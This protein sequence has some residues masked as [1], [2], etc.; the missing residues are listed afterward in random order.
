MQRH[1][2][3][4]V[5][6][7]FFLTAWRAGVT[8]ALTQQATVDAAGT[9]QAVASRQP[10]AEADVNLYMSDG[11]PVSAAPHLAALGNRCQQ[12]IRRAL[13]DMGQPPSQLS[14]YPDQLQGVTVAPRASPGD[15]RLVYFVLASRPDAVTMVSRLVRA[16]YHPSHLF[17]VHVDLKANTSLH[18]AFI[19][20]AEQRP[21]V[22]VLRTRRL[23]QWG[24]F[25]MVSALLDA[26]ASIAHRL[27]FDFFIN[28]SDAEIALRTNEEV[29]AFLRR[30]KGR[31]FMQIE[32]TAEAAEAAE[33]EAVAEA[34]AEASRE[35]EEAEEAAARGDETLQRRQRWQRQRQHFEHTHRHRQHWRWVQAV[36]RRRAFDPGALRSSPVIECGGFGFVSVN[37]TPTGHAAAPDAATAPAAAARQSLGPACCI[38]QS[39][40]LVHAELPFE[41][42][43]PPLSIEGGPIAREYRGSQ[44]AV[45]PADFC[46]ELLDSRSLARWAQVFERQLIPDERFLPTALMHTAFRAS[47]VNQPLRFQ[48]WP[49]GDAAQRD[50][51][52]AGLPASEWGGA[53]ALDVRALRRAMHSPM[54]FAKKLLPTR[55]ATLLPRY[56]A[57]MERKLRG[58]TDPHQPPIAAPLLRVDHD[59]SGF[60]AP[61]TPRATIG[62]DDDGDNGPPDAH[63]SLPRRVLRRRRVAALTF[64]DGTAC[65]CALDC[66]PPAEPAESPPEGAGLGGGGGGS[67]STEVASS[68]AAAV[69]EEVEAGATSTCCAQLSDGQAAL[70]DSPQ[71]APSDGG[72]GGGDGDGNDVEDGVGDR[73][74]GDESDAADWSI[75]VDVPMRPRRRCPD[76]SE[77]VASAA[78][79]T[80]V[81]VL[82]VNRAP[83]PV[84][85][86]HVEETGLE[87]AVLSLRAGE[88]AEVAAH[89]GHAWRVRTFGGALLRQLPATPLPADD[90]TGTSTLHIFECDSE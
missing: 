4:L 36:R 86:L 42:P 54:L 51:Y 58:W 83:H 5:A 68:A 25:S 38:G 18:D 76:A 35:A 29:V 48:A 69:V 17:L 70:C 22:H 59:L 57:W 15:V 20:F 71:A 89:S 8:T 40:P 14:V 23:V 2:H 62:G 46:R 60:G 75:Y 52:W 39:G 84:R 27:D 13:A 49:A 12:A 55:D 85:I 32:P 80:A 28:L 6:A 45:L 37:S 73:N 33:A 47:L 63:A 7:V 64:S 78:D 90:G 82:F 26:M 74:E 66:R 87:R 79:G 43:T 34:E 1:A 11:E 10:E 77:G 81:V 19:A 41:P 44:W 31:A 30:F 21:N 16:L 88:H 56:D 53:R 50:E 65:S 67:P 72:G 61:P 3:P 9:T 24:G